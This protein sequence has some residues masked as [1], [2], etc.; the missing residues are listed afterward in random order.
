[1]SIW[2]KIKSFFESDEAAIKAEVIAKAEAIIKA[3]IPTAAKALAELLATKGVTFDQA[4]LEEALTTFVL[5][6]E[7]KITGS[8]STESAASGEATA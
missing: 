5:A 2:S 8:T 4:F 3:E 7:S 6:E 1:M